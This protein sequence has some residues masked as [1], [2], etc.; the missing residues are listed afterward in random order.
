M[1]IAIGIGFGALII[2]AAYRAIKDLRQNKCAGCGEMNCSS[3]KK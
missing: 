2:W 3:R 1:S